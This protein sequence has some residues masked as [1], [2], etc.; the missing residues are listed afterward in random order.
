[1]NGL[2]LLLQAKERDP[3]TA[4]S[5]SPQFILMEIDIAHKVILKEH[6]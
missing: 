4:V 3:G 2:N 1:L 5:I 6:F